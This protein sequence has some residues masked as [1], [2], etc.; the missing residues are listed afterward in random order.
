MEAISILTKDAYEQQTKAKTGT[1][2]LHFHGN[3]PDNPLATS[4]LQHNMIEKLF[5]LVDMMRTRR[6]R[7]LAQERDQYMREFINRIEQEENMLL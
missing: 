2:V 7:V 1:A 3:Y 5:K 6:G 4:M